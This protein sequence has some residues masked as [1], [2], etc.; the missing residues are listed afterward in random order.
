[1][2]LQPPESVGWGPP[3]YGSAGTAASLLGQQ[4]IDRYD[5][6]WP[7]LRDVT[8]STF[9]RIDLLFILSFIPNEFMF[10][11]FKQAKCPSTSEACTQWES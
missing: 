3:S 11:F 4:R 7:S 6:A 1:M 2:I 9:S 10:Y 8:T 5:C